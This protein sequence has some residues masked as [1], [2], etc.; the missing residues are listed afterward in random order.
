MLIEKVART[1][2]RM[3]AGQ[4]ENSNLQEKLDGVKEN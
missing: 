1:E 2:E 4:K 3:N